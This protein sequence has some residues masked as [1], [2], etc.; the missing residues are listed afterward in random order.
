MDKSREILIGVIN[1]SPSEIEL[2]FTSAIKSEILDRIEAKRAE[3]GSNLLQQIRK[4]D[5]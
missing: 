4:S 3:V 5:D 2:S 1:Q